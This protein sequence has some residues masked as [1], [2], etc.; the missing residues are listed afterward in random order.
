[1]LKAA[2]EKIVSLAAPETYVIGGDTYTTASL[3]RV[4]PHIDRPREI[5]FSSLDGIV[6]AITTEINMVTRPVF[7]NVSSHNAV[8]VFTT[9]RPD[10]MQRDEL[11][12][13]VPELPSALPIWMGH[14]DAMIALRSRFIET[15]DSVYIMDLLSSIS[16]DNSIKTTDNGL[17]QMVNVRQGVSLQ[18]QKKIRPRVCLKPFRTFLEVDQPESE[19]LLRMQRGDP[20]KGKEAQIGLF[21]A[22]GGAWKLAAKHNVAEYFR[23]HLAELVGKGDVII[24]E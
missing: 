6:K 19:F 17:T 5:P 2:I 11:Y 23:E 4:T 20:D 8:S 1:M 3:K 22:D 7:V 14:D 9:Y 16:D 18:E 24:T 15:E 12:R 13:A 10:N 21:E